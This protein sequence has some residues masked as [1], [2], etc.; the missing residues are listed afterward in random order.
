MTE[1]PANTITVF[2]IAAIACTAPRV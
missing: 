2:H 1:E